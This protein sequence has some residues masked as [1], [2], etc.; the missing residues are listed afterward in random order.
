M[1]DLTLV[2]PVHNQECIIEQVYQD[3]ERMLKGLSISYECILVENGSTDK[4]LDVVKRIAHHYISVRR[5]SSKKGYGHAVLRGLSE[6]KG[7][8]VSYMPSDGQVDLSVFPVL[9][10]SIQADTWDIVKVKRM[11]RETVLRV[12]VSNVF[13]RIIS[14]IFSIPA[15]DI[16]G[17]PRIFLRK[18]LPLLDLSYGD[19]FIDVEFVVKSHDFGLRIVEFPMNTLPRAGGKSTRSLKTFI[20]FFMNIWQFKRRRMAK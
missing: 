4:T 2:L 14:Y 9:W 5:F 11:T 7:K 1:I 13:S 8:Y 18:W 3:I 12:I 16:N 6:A 17:S 19:S 15:I 20:E 10:K